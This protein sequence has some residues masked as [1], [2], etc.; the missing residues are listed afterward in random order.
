MPVASDGVIAARIF[1]RVE[2]H[3][4]GRCVTKLRGKR[5]RATAILSARARNQPLAILRLPKPR[6]DRQI[7]TRAISNERLNRYETLALVSSG[8]VARECG[9]QVPLIDLL[10]SYG[11]D[12]DYAMPPALPHGEFDYRTSAQVS[13]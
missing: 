7:D 13:A 9:A 6:C 1:A 11:A 3:P 5:Q 8:R 2:Q 4:N 10:C 12:P